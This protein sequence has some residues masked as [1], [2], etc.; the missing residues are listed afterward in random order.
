VAHSLGGTREKATSTGEGDGLAW[1][2]STRSIAN[3]QCVEAAG[4][5]HGRLAVRDSA[6]ITGP[7]IKFVAS[8]WRLFVEE[9]KDG[10]FD[11]L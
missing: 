7:M 10:G 8:Q 6:D 9:I 5:A 2:K 3:G 4:L 11:A 1:R